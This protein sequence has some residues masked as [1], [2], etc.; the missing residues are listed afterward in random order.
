M[1]RWQLQDAKAR[2]SEVVRRSQKD[3][4]QEI[5][6]HGKAAAIIVSK[7][8][9]ERLRRRRPSFVDF[10]RQSPLV[11]LRVKTERNGSK[12]RRIRL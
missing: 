4:P 7:E 3:G 11:G 2:L 8:D 9:F 5:T 10:L 1:G 12:T 6:L